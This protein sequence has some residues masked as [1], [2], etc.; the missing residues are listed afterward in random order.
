MGNPVT[1][2]GAL[3]LFTQTRPLEFVQSRPA[4]GLLQRLAAFGIVARRTNAKKYGTKGISNDRYGELP[5]AP[6][7]W[8]HNE[9]THVVAR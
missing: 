3:I 6:T 1:T 8:E 4:P 9:E 5:A 7:A 2:A